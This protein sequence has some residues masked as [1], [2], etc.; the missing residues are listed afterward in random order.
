MNALHGAI[1]VLFG[2]GMTV[3]TIEGERCA[4]SGGS[5]FQRLEV[6]EEGEA[7]GSGLRNVLLGSGCNV[8]YG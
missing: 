2:S 8:L 5:L 3:C 6:N 7:D 1:R 4:L